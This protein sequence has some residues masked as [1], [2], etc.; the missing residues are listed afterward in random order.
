MGADDLARNAEGPKEGLGFE[1]IFQVRVA[2][3]DHVPPDVTLIAF[4][5]HDHLPVVGYRTDRVFHAVWFDRD[6]KGRVYRH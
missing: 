2:V 1:Q 6:R 4:R 5:F 3:P